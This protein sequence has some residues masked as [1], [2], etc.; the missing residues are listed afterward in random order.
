M[1]KSVERKLEAQKLSIRREKQSSRRSRFLLVVFITT[2]I[3]TIGVFFWADWRAK[4]D[5]AHAE[6]ILTE[7]KATLAKKVAAE[8]ARQIAEAKKA[9]AE[10]KARAE[11]A[12][13]AERAAE[14]TKP[15]GTAIRSGD[16]GV[17]DPSALSVVINKKHCFAPLSWQP[18]D[19]TEVDGYPLRAEAATQMRAMMDAAAAAG[20]GFAISSSYRSYANQV[21]T[22]DY[23][24]SA[25]GSQAAADR[26]SAR[27]GYSEHQTGL[28]ADLKTGSCV[29]EC[30]GTTAAYTWLREHGAAYGYIQRYPTGLY[31]ITGYEPEAWHWRYV[32][33][34]TAQDMKAKGI[35]TLEEYFG[36]SG[37]DY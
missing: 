16:C 37:G 30:F 4:A 22:Y 9:E 14:Q 5:Q 11:Q 17:A 6:S 26:V 25:N 18:N 20:A 34:A 36:V 29:L 24:V 13:A 32:G 19:L 12:K 10:A 33:V 7:W 8:Q 3:V 23:W 1:R 15:S 31:S 35:E 27:P 21:A 28:V 2:F